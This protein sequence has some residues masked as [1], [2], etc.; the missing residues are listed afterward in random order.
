MQAHTM[1]QEKDEAVQ[2]GL[3]LARKGLFMNSPDVAQT[4]LQSNSGS[5]ACV[6]YS[7]GSLA[8]SGTSATIVG[9]AL[10]MFGDA[11][12]WLEYLNDIGDRKYRLKLPIIINIRQINDEEWTAAF[13]EAELVRSGDS[14]SEA[15]AW[16]RSSIIELYEL[17]KKQ[18]GKLGSLPQRQFRVLGR[19]IV[20][21]PN[22]TP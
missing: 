6:T 9:V 4:T 8:F 7:S 17:Y 11:P 10:G 14:P 21:K 20:E 1:L 5:T 3:L 22:T 13:E 18:G 2:A 12:E 19:Y 15:L 16:L